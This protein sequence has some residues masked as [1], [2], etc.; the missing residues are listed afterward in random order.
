MP[1]FFVM[2][3]VGAAL[4]PEWWAWRR[5]TLPRPPAARPAH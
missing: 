1:P 3:A 2:L 4:I 5:L